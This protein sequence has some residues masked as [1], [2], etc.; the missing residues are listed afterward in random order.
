MERL[1]L[2][3]PWVLLRKFRSM[4]GSLVIIGYNPESLYWNLCGCLI[5][6]RR[7]TGRAFWKFT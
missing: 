3:P 1:D 4:P 2:A 5:W 7:E 6:F